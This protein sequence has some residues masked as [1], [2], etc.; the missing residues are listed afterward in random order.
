[1][2]SALQKILLIAQIPTFVKNAYL[3][4]GGINLQTKL[5][6]LKKYSKELTSL[7]LFINDLRFV[8]FSLSA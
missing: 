4:P 7:F 3:W 8:L 6:H 1:M 5:F 2:T